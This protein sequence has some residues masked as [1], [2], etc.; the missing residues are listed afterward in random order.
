MTNIA[1]LLKDAP[2]DM[3]LYSP[4][5]G[6]VK[7]DKAGGMIYVTTKYGSSKCFTET[8]CYCVD[9]ESFSTECLLFPSKDCRTW[10]EWELP[11]KAGH[12]V[13]F[14]ADNKL[15]LMGNDGKTFDITGKENKSI[16]GSCKR[17]TLEEEQNFF[18]QLCLNGYTWNADKKELRKIQHYD[19]ANFHEGMPVLVRDDNSDEWNYLLFSHYR[20]KFSDH[21]FAGGNPW[22]Q[23]IP[24]N[25]E[26][27]HLLG[28]AD[29]C[30]EQYINW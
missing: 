9:N 23:C 26:T 14:I 4:L 22:C 20:T 3:K 21:F 8:G 16:C 17:V 19:I 12:V 5:F 28:T 1:K 13:M 18:A 15:Y 10:E 27:K 30:D 6:E 25:E 24:L 11:L 2:K 7:L 29:M